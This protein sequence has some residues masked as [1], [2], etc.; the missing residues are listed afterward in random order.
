MNA[1]ILESRSIIIYSFN[2]KS[3][4]KVWKFDFFRNFRTSE[5]SQTTSPPPVRECPKFKNHPPPHLPDVLCA[6][7]EKIGSL[8][9]IQ[10][11]HR[12]RR[13][14]SI[15]M[16]CSSCERIL[17]L[18]TTVSVV[19][20]H[21]NN[22]IRLTIQY[23][24]ALTTCVLIVLSSEFSQHCLGPSTK[25]V[26]QNLGFSNHPLPLSGCV[27][28]SKT[29]PPRQWRNVNHVFHSAPPAEI[30]GAPTKY[31]FYCHLKKKK[32]KRSPLFFRFFL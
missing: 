17:C 22:T 2:L 4:D 16:Q 1:L 27:R 21:H 5:L 13:W 32:K 23:K 19:Y 12:E 25:D 18:Y 20:K 24:A 8:D 29:T 7:L 10:F 11:Q 15:L 3:S 30:F 26:R 31:F 28:I 6:T 9:I 14:S